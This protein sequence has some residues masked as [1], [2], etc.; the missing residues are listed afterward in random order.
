MPS[1]VRWS[2]GI[3]MSPSPGRSWSEAW[4]GRTACCASSRSRWTES[5]WTPQVCAR[6]GLGGPRG[7][8]G[9]SAAAAGSPG[10]CAMASAFW[11]RRLGSWPEGAGSGCVQPPRAHASLLSPACEPLEGDLR[12]ADRVW[13]HQAV[14]EHYQA[15]GP[16]PALPQPCFMTSSKALPLW[17]MQESLNPMRKDKNDAFSAQ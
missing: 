15:P 9:P 4:P 10:R 7:R 6:A 13:R 14:R 11:G 16:H 3:Q 5:S 2:S 12:K 8:L 1:A 17:N